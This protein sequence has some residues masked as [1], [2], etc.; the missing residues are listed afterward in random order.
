MSKTMAWT[1]FFAALFT[2]ISLK[3]L[4]F[5]NFIKWSPVGWAKKWLIFGSK[6]EYSKWVLLFIILLIVFGIFYLVSKLTVNISPA[7]TA[8]VISVICAV[9]LEWVIYSPSTLWEGIKSISIPFFSIIAVVSRFVTG[10][11]VY[12]VKSSINS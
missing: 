8:L 11:A 4:Q 3:F 2:L 6:N 5:F 12:E 1:S 10:T 7:I 9:A